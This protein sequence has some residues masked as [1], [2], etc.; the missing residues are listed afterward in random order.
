MYAPVRGVKSTYIHRKDPVFARRRRRR[1]PFRRLGGDIFGGKNDAIG[2]E[3]S[4]LWCFWRVS[5]GENDAKK[6]SQCHR[7][8]KLRPCIRLAVNM[9]HCGGVGLLII[10]PFTSVAAW[11][12][13]TKTCFGCFWRVSGGEND[14]RKSSQ[15]HIYMAN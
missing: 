8:G 7:Y 9:E 10:R 2:G 15:C 1:R 4:V 5:G 12:V 6:S 3:M 13:S 14:A 11:M